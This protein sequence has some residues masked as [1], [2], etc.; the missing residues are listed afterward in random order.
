MKMKWENIFKS[1]GFACD[2][3]LLRNKSEYVVSKIKEADEVI[4]VPTEIK[5]QAERVALTPVGVKFLTMFGVKVI[6]EKGA[7]K[8][9]FS[10]EDYARAGAE[11]VNTAEEVWKRATIIKKVKEP[12]PS[13]FKYFR[14]G[15]TIF[16]YLHLASPEMKDL[17]RELLDKKVRSIAYETIVCFMN[18]RKRTPALQPMSKIAGDLG[19]YFAMLY[20]RYSEVKGDN[21]DLTP[22]GKDLRNKI[23]RSYPRSCDLVADI[24]MKG[25][26][27]LILGAG[28][29]GEHMAGT[30]LMLGADVTVADIREDILDELSGVFNRYGDK[31]TMIR[32]KED[33]NDPDES[34]V[35]KY[36]ESD[37]IGG[38][39]LVPGGKAPQIRRELLDRISR[40]KKKVIIDIALDQGG[41]FE[42]AHS[43]THENPVFLDECGNIRYCVPNMPDAVGKAAAIELEKS[44]IQYTLVLAM[45]MEESVNIFPEMAGGMNLADGYIVHPEIRKAYPD[46]PYKRLSAL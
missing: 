33:V 43:C 27:A 8:T 31:I 15:L 10:D 20:H 37:I 22:C 24:S 5:P 7:G 45:G 46:M 21:V 9:H 38:C 1:T 16:T 23:I 18:G 2:A 14:R 32:S 13:E 6:V 30:L 44:N 12:L 17:T 26:K 35:E 28:M 3:R 40:K 4:G 39:I 36:I 11:V 25:A 41:N 29:A 34:L 42:G 19:G